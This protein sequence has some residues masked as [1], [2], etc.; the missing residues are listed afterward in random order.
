MYLE[1][2]FIIIMT[3]YC[4]ETVHLSYSEKT[5]SD[6]FELRYG[7]MITALHFPDELDEVLN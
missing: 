2:F 1:C 6:S 3:S 7:D 4:F 5:G